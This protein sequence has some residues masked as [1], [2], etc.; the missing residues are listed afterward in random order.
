MLF[1]FKMNVCF[2]QIAVPKRDEWNIF[3]IALRKHS[4]FKGKQALEEPEDSLGLEKSCW[5]EKWMQP[6]YYTRPEKSIGWWI[7]AWKVSGFMLSELINTTE[8][9]WVMEAQR[10][11]PASILGAECACFSVRLNNVQHHNAIRQKK[12]KKKKCSLEIKQS[13]ITASDSHAAKLNAV[14]FTGAVFITERPGW[15]A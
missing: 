10:L 13:W 15:I 14:M 7:P 8:L 11:L 5:V 3:N 6:K 2:D 4:V 12:K 9:H 1:C